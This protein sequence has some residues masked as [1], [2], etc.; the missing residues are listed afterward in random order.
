M[1]QL[2]EY[3][4]EA[5]AAAATE[6]QRRLLVELQPAVTVVLADD[7]GTCMDLLRARTR[8]RRKAAEAQAPRLGRSTADDKRSILFDGQCVRT[9]ILVGCDQTTA[10]AEE[11]LVCSNVSRR[12]RRQWEDAKEEAT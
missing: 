10:A 1:L 5:A 9:T 11:V 7:D 6:P 2:L 12:I 3:V 8:G 4:V